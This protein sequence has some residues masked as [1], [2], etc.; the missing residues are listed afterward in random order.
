MQYAHGGDIYTYKNLLD[1]SINVNPLGPA[2]AVVE[3]AARS[4]QRIGEYPD[5]RSRELRNA[6]AEKK[7]L[8]AERFVIGNGAADL[9]FSLVL[10]EKPQKAMIVIPAFSEYE[11]ALKTVGCEILYHEVKKENNFRLGTDLT[12]KITSELDF[13]FLCSPSNPAGQAVEK[14]FLIK[15]A[16]KCEKERVRLVLDECFVQFLTSGE[17]ASMQLETGRFRY[18]FVLQAFTKIYAVPGIR[19]G[20]GISSDKALL[21]RM[22]TV[23]QPWSV[24]TPAQAAGLSALKED[25]REEQTRQLVK[26][27][28]ERMEK[29]LD[30]LQKENP[31]ASS[32]QK[33]TWIYRIAARDAE[34]ILFPSSPFYAE[35]DTGREQNSVTASFPPQPGIGCWLMKQYPDFVDEY[36][37]WSG[38]YGKYEIGRA[39][40]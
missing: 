32:F 36:G 26:S 30:R 13:L 34:V 29:E 15:I 27:E 38:Y 22:E 31:K 39:H 2:D 14:E 3:A 25:H 9:L 21:E 11:Q 33:K 24:S 1:F 23:R 20:Y 17:E 6:L 18:L 35:I 37:E 7:G 8:A 5:S 28:R 19:L 4:L 16:E 40:V 10:A 12:E